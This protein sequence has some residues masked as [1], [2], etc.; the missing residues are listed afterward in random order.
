MKQKISPLAIYTVLLI[1]VVVVSIGIGLLIQHFNWVQEQ[2]LASKPLPRDNKEVPYVTTPNDVVDKML[3]LCEI[4]KDD[5]VYDLGCGDGRIVIAAA[6]KYGCRA[7]GFDIDEQLIELS[8]QNAQLEGVEEL[9][10]FH[11]RDI[12]EVDISEATVVT[13]FLRAHLNLRLV[14]QLFTLQDGARIVSHNFEMPG[15]PA[16]QHFT[17]GTK[18][19]DNLHEVYFWKTPLKLDP[20]FNP[21]QGTQ[22][23]D[24]LLAIVKKMHWPGASERLTN[25]LKQQAKRADD[26]Q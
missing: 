7:F 12:Y 3:E 26:T 17:M 24:E 23:H 13:L 18:E 8:K 6:K 19:D 25:E 21:E 1:V 4:G 22:E 2:S 20:E 9:V 5:I 11:A 15:V 16:E 14:P 10:E